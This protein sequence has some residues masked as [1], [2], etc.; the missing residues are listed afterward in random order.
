MNLYEVNEALEQCFQNAIDP[1]TGLIVD[2]SALE[3]MQALEK[4]RDKILLYC[5]AAFKNRKAWLQ[6]QKE[7]KAE[8]ERKIKSL[9]NQ[10]DGI[11]K[12][13]DGALPDGSKLK[14]EHHT[15]YRQK[16]SSVL[17]KVDPRELPEE[18]QKVT[19]EPKKKLI[20]AAL[21]AGDDLSYFAELEESTSLVIK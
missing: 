13:M 15:M 2:E 6:S 18:F 19:V 17:L 20:A 11:K 16:N 1:D 9:Q 8:T 7:H 3:S 5:A 21:K 14:N 10:M 12:Y 4:E